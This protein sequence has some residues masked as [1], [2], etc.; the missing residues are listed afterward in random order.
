ML[1]ITERY[2]PDG[3][4]GELATHLVLELLRDHFEIKVVTGTE[5]PEMLKGVHY[6]YEPLLS[7]R[8]KIFLWLNTVRLAKANRFQKLLEWSDIVYVPRFSFPVIPEAK[9]RR[10]RVIVHLHDYIPISYTAT[11][12][13]P[14]EKHKSTITRDDIKIE[15]MKGIKHCLAASALWWLPRLARR[16]ISHADK[17][18][19]VSNR[20]ANIMKMA[21]S[22]LAEKI[23][24]IYNPPPPVPPIKKRLKDPCFLYVGGDSCLKGFHIMLDVMK[25]VLQKGKNIK[26]ILTNAY[27]QKSRGLIEKIKKRTG[28]KIMVMGRISHRN[29]LLLHSRCYALLF[30]SI[31]EEPLPY[32]LIEAVK[33]RTIPIATK[34][35]G[36]PEILGPISNQKLLINLNDLDYLINSLLEFSEYD[37]HYL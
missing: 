5:S 23:T 35:G 30:P 33:M 7:R 25:R 37:Q 3:G 10:K 18:I 20:Q 31:L 11:I 19:C 2:W 6:I 9:K 16:W 12:L 13:A 17:I 1:V 28:G 21:A 14:F 4:G 26:F 22:E 32:A 36:I 34:V 8:E 15:Y 29:L 27:N 24:V